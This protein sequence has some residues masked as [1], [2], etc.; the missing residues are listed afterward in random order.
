[1]PTIPAVTIQT[2]TIQMENEFMQA[3][4]EQ[5]KILAKGAQGIIDYFDNDSLPLYNFAFFLK[6]IIFKAYR[7]V[8]PFK[9][10]KKIN[11]VPDAVYR[12]LLYKIIDENAQIQQGIQLKQN[13]EI[14]DKKKIQRIIRES[15]FDN[16]TRIS[17]EKVFALAFALNLDYSNVIEL[18][19]KGAGEREF[20]FRNSYEVLLAYCFIEHTHMYEYYTELRETFENR[21]NAEDAS[22]AGTDT[23]VFK[24]NFRKI[25]SEDELMDFICSLPNDES[26]SARREFVRLYDSLVNIYNNDSLSDKMEHTIFYG[27]PSGYI[28][29]AALILREDVVQDS[30]RKFNQITRELF[31]TVAVNKKKENGQ[32]VRFRLLKEKYAMT[33]ADLLDV[34]KGKKSVQ[35]A[36]LISLSFL[37]YVKDGGWEAAVHEYSANNGELAKIFNDFSHFI[38]PVLF[39]AGYNNFSLLNEFE[40]FVMR[41][42]YTTDPIDSFRQ[43]MLTEPEEKGDEND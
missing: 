22:N 13:A 17:R 15:V 25:E 23:I 18:L 40:L 7:E 39:R 19:Q 43:V 1:M 34:Y 6:R 8:P 20:N 10:A 2:A 4:A 9:E 33:A 28:N 21:Y 30:D 37:E 29:L 11:D 31:G 42:L 32:E 3:I 26:Q 5:D 16:R 27:D 38:N 14:Y 36:H 35:K 41:C 12:Q 24:R